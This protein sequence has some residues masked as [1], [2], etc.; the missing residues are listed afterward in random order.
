M[1]TMPRCLSSLRRAGARLVLAGVLVACTL[2]ADSVA[3]A[4]HARNDVVTVTFW[5]YSLDAAGM[6]N[7]NKQ[8]ALFEKAYPTIK[9]KLT[10]FTN[11]QAILTA[12]AGGNP[13][14]AALFYNLANVGDWGQRGALMNLD[15][16]IK[17]NHLDMS[18]LARP[19]LRV[20]TYNGHLYAMPVGLDSFTLYINLDL[21]HAAGLTRYP[22]TTSELSA[23]AIKLTKHD[24]SGRMTQLGLGTCCGNTEGAELLSPLFNASFYDRTHRQVTPDN[25]GVLRTLQWEGN[26]VNKMGRQSYFDFTHAKPHNDGGDPFIDGNV[27]MALDGEWMCYSIPH[28]ATKKFHWINVP[29]PYED[30]HPEWKMS[31]FLGG[32]LTGIPSGAKHPNEAIKWLWYETTPQE[33]VLENAPG[34]VPVNVHAASILARQSACN[35]LQIKIGQGARAFPW[36]VLPVGGQYSSAFM[37]AEDKILHGQD[38]PAHAMATLKQSI[39]SALDAVK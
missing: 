26:L 20:S 24:A 11:E 19:A 5:T 18:G 6:R 15:P 1:K 36:P 8:I 28:F 7:W 3:H 23:D 38:A 25:A 9:I 4:Q 30:G 2:A 32:T 17:A 22:T 37:A 34:G 35:A 29:P 14:D 39:Q 27:A 13:P 31:T 21:F 12:V 33:Q 16:L 10:T